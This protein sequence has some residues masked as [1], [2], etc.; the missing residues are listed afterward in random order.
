M[1]HADINIVDDVSQIQRTI[2]NCSSP[3]A[4]PLSAITCYASRGREE[5]GGRRVCVCG[6]VGVGGEE[7]SG[8]KGVWGGGG[9][10]A[11]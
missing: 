10:G 6:W 9:G 5:V 4:V 7:V 8:G 2:E 11:M 3:S 1:N